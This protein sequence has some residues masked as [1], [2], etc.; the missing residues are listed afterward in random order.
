MPIYYSPHETQSARM[1]SVRDKSLISA[2]AAVL[3]RAPAEM[4]CSHEEFA[5]AAG[6]E[7]T[8]VSLLETGKWKP[9]LSV[10]FAHA[11]DQRPE[12]LVTRTR[13]SEFAVRIR[14]GP[15]QSVG[16]KTSGARA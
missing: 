5:E 11:L 3:R 15:G 9:P 1:A 10:I 13:P 16:G 8:F 6:V 2:F 12:T 4:R 7:R 14:S